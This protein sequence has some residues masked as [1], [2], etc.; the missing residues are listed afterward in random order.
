[1]PSR[2]H[3]PNHEVSAEPEPLAYSVA[4]TL[5]V[6]GIGRTAFYENLVASGRLRTVVVGG[7]RLVPR[8]AVVA[9]LEE[10]GDDAP[11]A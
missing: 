9:L 1:M 11:A 2:G 5:K 3:R 7:R 10:G 8:T 6:L 4:E